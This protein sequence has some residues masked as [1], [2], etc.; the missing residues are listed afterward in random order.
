L[1]VSTTRFEKAE[2]IMI[3]GSTTPII[4]LSGFLGAGKTTWLRQA[5]QDKEFS[6]SAVLVNEFGAVGIDHMLMG[7]IAND[8]VL[9]QSGCVCCQIRGELR[10]AVL[11]LLSQR[12]AGDVPWFSRIVIETTGLADPGQIFSTLLKDP[13]LRNQVNLS[14]VLTVVDAK[15][16]LADHSRQ[17]EWSAQVAAASHILVS[18]SDL[19]VEN[20]LTAVM[21]ELSRCNPAATISLADLIPQLDGS[22]MNFWPAAVE[23][24]SAALRHTQTEAL[25]LQVDHPVDW[26]RFVAWLSALIHAH[27]DKLLRVKCLLNTR[28]HGVVLLDGVQHTLH[29]PQHLEDWKYEESSSRLVFISRGLGAGQIEASLQRLVFA[30]KPN[31]AH[32]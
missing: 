9:L 2:N 28:E 21:K 32:R 8:V 11:R 7:E 12:T 19:V 1:A 14:G 22:S 20:S 6:D 5:L 15:H 16:A 4:I 25:A 27:G 29:Q 23:S 26:Y 24:G 18:K 13:V 10:D 31:R 3:N 17:P 30:L